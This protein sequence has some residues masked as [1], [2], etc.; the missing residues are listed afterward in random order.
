MTYVRLMILIIAV[1]GC[2]SGAGI[3]EYFGKWQLK[4]IL[5]VT[6]G[7][8]LYQEQAAALI[9]SWVYYSRNEAR[10][11]DKECKNPS[12]EEVYLSQDEFLVSARVSAKKL[13]ITSS[14]IQKVLVRDRAGNIWDAP[15]CLFFVRDRDSLV[16]L[17]QGIFFEMKNK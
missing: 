17:Y 10:V 4:R 15:G 13:G 7:G 14:T 2:R 6:A 9:G 16:V 11:G 12:Y 8:A 5:P 3:P 1:F